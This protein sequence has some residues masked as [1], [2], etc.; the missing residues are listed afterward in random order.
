LK[1]TP[2]YDNIWGTIY[3]SEIEQCDNSP[4]KTGD[5]SIINPLK[6]SE[7]RWIAISQ[8]M[9]NCGYR[10]ELLNNDPSILYKGNIQYGDTIWIESPNK[11]ING[12]WVVHDAKNSRYRNTIDFLQTKGDGSLYNNDILWNGKFD[13]LK[14]FAYEDGKKVN[15]NI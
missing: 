11:N 9:L 1:I 3:H 7:H 2:I 15:N 12:W 8:E 14:I 10:M 5:G 4:R 6:A 13:G